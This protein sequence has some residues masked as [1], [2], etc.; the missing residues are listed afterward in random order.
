M[1]VLRSNEL[2][3]D[4]KQHLSLLMLETGA[5]IARLYS[6]NDDDDNYYYF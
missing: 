6:D 5:N 4:L 1:N 3:L 2:R